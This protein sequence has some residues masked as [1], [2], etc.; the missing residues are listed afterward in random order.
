[1]QLITNGNFKGFLN[2]HFSIFSLS[3]Y[4]MFCVIRSLGELVQHGKNGFVFDTHLELSQ[5]I[6]T[7]F[8]DF[9]SNIT[10]VNVKE[11]ISHRLKEFQQSRW[12]E[13]WNEYALPVFLK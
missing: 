2:R 8:C 7:W 9:P 12:N 11:T 13:N 10:L 5:Q 6:L 3:Y 4:F 1:M